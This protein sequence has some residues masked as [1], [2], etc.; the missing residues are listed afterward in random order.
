MRVSMDWTEHANNLA[1]LERL[2]ADYT[3]DPRSV[4]EA[5]AARR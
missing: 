5:T 2:Y 1:F 3:A 4:P